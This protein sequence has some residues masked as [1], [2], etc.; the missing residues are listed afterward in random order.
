[1]TTI[2]FLFNTITGNDYES[3]IR[4]IQNNKVNLNC[5]NRTG[6]S[7]LHKAIEVRAKECFDILINIPNYLKNKSSK[8]SGL[9]KAIEYYLI[10]NNSTNYYYLNNLLEK[11]VEIDN[12]S[13]IA[14]IN[15]YD[16]FNK[17]F[18]ILEI[19]SEQLIKDILHNSIQNS[20][21]NIIN[22]IYNYLENN[23]CSYYLNNKNEFNK[24]FFKKSLD[25]IITVKVLIDKNIDWKII[26]HWNCYIP[27]IYYLIKYDI[28]ET[29]N[30]FYNLYLNLS[31]NDLNSIENIN[32]FLYL[33][34]IINIQ[35]K[36]NIYY[37]GKILE[38][39]IDFIDVSEFSIELYK[40][41]I[42]KHFYI[43]N[44]ENI[45]IEFNYIYD[46]IYLLFIKN[47]IKINPF[48]ILNKYI[49]DIISTY[50][51]NI[52][53][54][55]YNKEY[56]LKY[57]NY[58]IKI[59]YIFNYFKYDSQVLNSKISHSNEYT[60]NQKDSSL[61]DNDKINLITEFQHLLSSVENEVAT[62]KTI[63]I[64]DSSSEL[65]I[66]NNSKDLMLIELKT[67]YINYQKKIKNL[68]KK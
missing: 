9:L 13:L 45:F 53:K 68:S 12:Q 2:K 22:M 8:D 35:N 51:E 29:F 36:N 56:Q 41:M 32:S 20:N 21:I 3:L 28:I 47:K 65:I 52:N 27:T 23:S 46:L 24:I 19:K 55:K 16:I 10:S 66:D 17:I 62:S 18:N 60:E 37:F 54:L 31:K 15:N 14:T 64:A 1:M 7:L 44:I 40:I 63:D 30:Y 59:F 26:Y 58:I 34:K 57:S 25:N 38:L 42:N 49:K 5:H 33:L 61:K 48:I 39:P 43:H 67:N 11:N 50:N 6:Y 4:I